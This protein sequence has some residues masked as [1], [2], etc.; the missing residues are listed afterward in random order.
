MSDK[1]T[2]IC[3]QVK[4]NATWLFLLLLFVLCLVLA[5]N[6]IFPFPGGF[7]IE[8]D[9]P[10]TS[11]TIKSIPATTITVE[12]D[13]QNKIVKTI[14]VRA[15]SEGKTLWDGLS[16]VVVPLSLAMLGYWLQKEQQKRAEQF[17]EEEALQ[18]YIDK[19]S[20]LLID[21]NLIAISTKGKNKTTEEE[22]LLNSCLT[23]I[24]SRTLSIL[25]LFKNDPDRKS[26]VIRFLIEADIVYKLKLNLREADLSGA[27][28]L[29]VNLIRAKLAFTK[30]TNVNFRF[31]KLIGANLAWADLESAKCEG[32][33]LSFTNLEG[34]NLKG[35]NLEGAK[36]CGA[37]LRS[38]KFIKAN[39]ERAN[40][41][42][43]NLKGKHGYSLYSDADLSFANLKNIQWD[44]NT[45][46]PDKEA[47]TNVKNIPPEL[48]EHLGL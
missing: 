44:S 29:G 33:R 43:A 10:L 4:K 17:A 45:L 34:A 36:L 11:A 5:S 16:L 15:H 9:P 7:G 24:R 3:A 14:E 42:G 26:R 31:A 39:L 8:G 28:L 40:L 23:I 20:V 38:A 1:L 13:K 46:W 41:K 25:Q 35:A 12:K 47:F 22:E 27:T 2:N 21:K 37:K 32:A 19:I 18:A 48:K 30:F 6:K